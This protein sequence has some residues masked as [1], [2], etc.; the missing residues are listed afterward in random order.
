MSANRINTADFLRGQDFHAKK[1][2][3]QNFLT[4]KNILPR[5]VEESDVSHE[6]TILEIGPGTGNLTALLADSA[7][8]VIAVEID[9]D[10]IPLLR[11][12]LFPRKNIEII[13]TDI[14]KA[15]LK[16]VLSGK[17]ENQYFEDETIAAQGEN[18]SHEAGGETENISHEASGETENNIPDDIRI[19]ANLPYYITTPVITK[20]L[21]ESHF[22]KSITVMVQKEVAERLAASPGSKEYGA[23]T[24]FSQYYSVPKIL[25]YVPRESFYP[26]PKV[27]SAIVRFDILEK[28]PYD[29]K[30]P[31]LMFDIIRAAFNERRKTL[32][33]AVSDAG[34]LS[35]KKEQVLSALEKMGQSPT[36]RGER[37]SLQAFAELSDILGSS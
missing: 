5:I 27:E 31:T 20:L 17:Y 9:R 23:I 21:E 36:V 18:T 7:K 26:P 8:K 16:D 15:S 33:N 19:V 28:P 1:K 6:D 32:A 3:G 29:M 12:N 14:M 10:L 25:F 35:F 30:N 13:N 2:Y 22:F 4:D 34:N 37:L 24:L 11:I